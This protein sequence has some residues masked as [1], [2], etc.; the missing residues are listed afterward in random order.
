M[1]DRVKLKILNIEEYFIDATFEKTYIPEVGADIKFEYKNFKGTYIFRNSSVLLDGSL[2]KFYKHGENYD[3]FTYKQVKEAFQIIAKKFNKELKDIEITFVEIGVNMIMTSLPEHYINCFK[4]LGRNSF[5][6]MTPLSGSSKLTG[7]R[8]KSSLYD[9]KVYNKSADTKAK[10]VTKAKPERNILRV[11]IS[12]S[13]N[14][15]RT[16]KL[17]FNAEQLNNIRIFRKYIRLLV[18]AFMASNK[19]NVYSSK[20]LIGFSD[21]EVKDYYFFTSDQYEL[22]IQYLKEVGRSLKNENARRKKLELKL[23][24]L[25]ISNDYVDEMTI[26]FTNKRKKLMD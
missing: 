13:S 16:N 12:L 23:M 26:E 4:T 14:Y 18:R 20:D 7:K 10:T 1:L 19:I 2:H 21:K 5:I 3:D 24:T 9:F 6:Y 8:C 11:E 25:D 15:L 17:L 22:Y